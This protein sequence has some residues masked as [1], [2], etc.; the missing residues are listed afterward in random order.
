M[1]LKCKIKEMSVALANAA[2]HHPAEPSIEE[3]MVASEGRRA[4]A[5]RGG[6]K[7]AVIGSGAEGV[8]SQSANE[9][10]ASDHDEAEDDQLELKE[11]G[12][13][14]EVSKIRKEEQGRR[15]REKSRLREKSQR[16][17]E[18]S[19]RAREMASQK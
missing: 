3:F 13:I 4:G 8:D 19:Q 5:I 2:H 9:N 6:G 16:A 10:G 15:R 12:T 17:R 14:E 1:T 18:M 7:E 11:I